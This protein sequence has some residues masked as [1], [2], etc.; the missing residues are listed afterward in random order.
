MSSRKRHPSPNNTDHRIINNITSHDRDGLDQRSTPSR[1]DTDIEME[2]EGLK[3]D[4]SSIFLLLL[5]YV[6]QGI[7]LGLAGSIPLVLQSRKISYSMQAV[8]SFVYWPFSVK[9][10]WAPIVDS[11][12]VPRFGR[13]KT[14]LVPTQ[15]LIGFFMLFL[16]SHVPTILGDADPGEGSSR[17]DVYFLTAVFFMLNFLAATQD[18]AVD[19]WALTMLSKRN[20]GY[21]STCNS[22]G[23]TAG[24]FLGNVVFLALESADFCNRYLRSEPKPHGVV[25]LSDFLYFWACVFLVTTTLV[26]LLKR[27]K[28]GHGTEDE[29]S[30]GVFGTY[31]QL[32]K[33]MKLPALKSYVLFA[34][35]YKIGFAAADAVTGLKLIEEGVPREKLA[36]LAVPMVPL[37]IILPWIISK[38]S[39]GPRPLDLLISAIPFRLLIGGVVFSFIVWWTPYVKSETGEFPTYYYAVLVIVYA[40]YQIPLNCIFVS[41]MIFNARVSDPRIGGTYMTLLNT[42]QNLGGNWPVTVALWLVDFLTWKSCVGGAAGEGAE[43]DC[44]NKAE[45]KAC[46][47]AGGHCETDIDGYYIEITACLIIGFC[48][49]LWQSKRVR[50]LQDL[51]EDAWKC[52]N[53]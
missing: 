26:A 8:F 15:Y 2:A 16:S 32:Y 11:L 9:L 12:F 18:I 27:E 38:Y 48:W 31:K 52:P 51:N 28:K 40:V 46:S 50:H 29:L 22:V 19:G 47:E 35:T 30:C 33:L 4:Y 7:P 1:E 34:L 42:V 20:V 44:D 23:Q 37:Q 5:L 49:L 53:Q 24:Y 45:A 39:S 21:A 14:W 3:G 41:S 13:R 25:T 36:L 17:V 10:I 43:L 6:L